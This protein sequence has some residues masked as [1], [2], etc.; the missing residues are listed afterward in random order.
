MRR[1][2]NVTPYR[3]EVLERMF[4]S[5]RPLSLVEARNGGRNI[6]PTLIQNGWAECC[7]C[8]DGNHGYVIT[9]SGRRAIGFDT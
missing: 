4:V 7:L 1:T 6:M 9:E 5:S 8:P 3:R 2:F